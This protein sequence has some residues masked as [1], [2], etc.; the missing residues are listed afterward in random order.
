VLCSLFVIPL[1]LMLTVLAWHAVWSS[2]CS[3][4]LRCFQSRAGIGGSGSSQGGT[5]TKQHLSQKQD[6][7]PV[8]QAGCPPQVNAQ[9]G[10]R[11]NLGARLI[12]TVLVIGFDFYS[13]LATY[14]IGMLMCLELP[15]GDASPPRHWVLDVRLQC[16][17][18]RLD[19]WWGVRALVLGVVLLTICIVY[20]FGIAAVL[21]TKA[22]NGQLDPDS[23][24]GKKGRPAGRLH[25]LWGLITSNLDFRFA[26]Y[27]VDYDAWSKK[28]ATAA[29]SAEQPLLGKGPMSWCCHYLSVLHS[30][31]CQLWQIVTGL[32]STPLRDTMKKAREGVLC[33]MSFDDHP[34]EKF[35]TSLR[36]L[37]VLAWDSILDLQRL[38]LAALGLSVMLHEQ[39]QL[40]L[41]TL[42]LVIYLA[43]M[44]AVRPWRS[45][46]ILR[47]QVLAASVLVLSCC[48]ILASNVSADGHY[49]EEDRKAY[50]TALGWTVIGIN[51]LYV[52]VSLVTLGY[53]A[54]RKTY[55]WH[56]RST[57]QDTEQVSQGCWLKR[58][59]VEW[60]E[61]AIG[62]QQ[63]AAV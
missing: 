35:L 27:K 24:S 61:E 60:A 47:L 38:V 8:A 62:L 63:H 7:L 15:A 57:K 33:W 28:G 58:L 17:T 55:R 34:V 26:D 49:S 42:V 36:M 6:W 2:M 23:K 59:I 25:K 31:C 56:E 18:R 30:W 10:C 22:R 13:T 3:W 5:K 48:V 32:V 41:V 16:P 51:L 45:P 11:S 54:G 52:V 1:V 14:A 37:L 20:P 9:R 44:L 53:C 39:H 29:L 50:T 46:A 12:T 19:Q 4:I 21:V 43:L 40:L